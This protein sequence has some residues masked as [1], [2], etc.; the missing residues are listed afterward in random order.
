MHYPA[1][2]HTGSLQVQTIVTIILANSVMIL[3]FQQLQFVANQ[4]SELQQ[5]QNF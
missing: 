3:T 5:S 2:Q 4:V 1:L